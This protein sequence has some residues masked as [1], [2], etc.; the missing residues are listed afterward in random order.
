MTMK[1]ST[2][3]CLPFAGFYESEWTRLV[4]H[5]EEM[6]IENEAESELERPEGPHLEAHEIGGVWFNYMDYASAYRAI[7]RD[8]VDAFNHAWDDCFGWHP[9]LVFEKMESPRFYNF[10]TDRV[11]AYIPRQ[12]I[13]RLVQINRA[14]KWQSFNK[15]AADR[16]TSYD[17][18]ISFYSACRADWGRVSGWDHNQLETLLLAAMD[19]EGYADNMSDTIF[20]Y[21][22]E[23]SYEYIDQHM[24][25]QGLK[26]AL[27]DLR[28]EKLEQERK[29]NP[30]YVPPYRCPDTPNLF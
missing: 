11:F 13:A 8:Y 30:D 16:H 12:T 10:E 23:Q 28:A 1:P 7:A 24:N 22:A 26:A 4:D 3:I 27:D 25:W 18:F 6:A 9:G 17:G 21:V 15:V 19:A 5:D 2:I 20:E 14:G 29:H